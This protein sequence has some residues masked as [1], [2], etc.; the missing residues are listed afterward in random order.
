MTISREI[1]LENK[2]K[3]T[4]YIAPSYKSICKPKSIAT[5]NINEYFVKKFLMDEKISDVDNFLSQAKTN[6][7]NRAICNL[8][9]C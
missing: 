6:K 9:L 4:R 1:T 5:E 7:T 3:L 2:S 8:P